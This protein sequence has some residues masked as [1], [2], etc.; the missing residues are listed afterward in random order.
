MH[1]VIKEPKGCWF[2][3]NRGSLTR[4]FLSQGTPTPRYPRFSS[5]EKARTL[6]ASEYGT[7]PGTGLL[8]G[9]NI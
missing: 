2:E 7:T 5:I 8:E 4:S 9:C 3:S 6:L 1:S